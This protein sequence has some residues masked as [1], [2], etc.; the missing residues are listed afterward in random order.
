MLGTGGETVKRGTTS[1]GKI[2]VT[3][4]WSGG[5]TGIFRENKGYGGYAKGTSGEGEVG[6]FDGYRPLAVEI[7]KF[8]K[9]KTAPVAAEETLEIYAFMET[10]DESKRRGGEAV[11]LSEVREKA[12]LAAEK[13][14]G[15]LESK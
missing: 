5:R 14:L 7:V 15:L 10:A 9:S 2:E 12:Q 3:G 13:Q 6:K 8:F 1:E 4:S 11:K